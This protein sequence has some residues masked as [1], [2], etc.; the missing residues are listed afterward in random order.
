M[1]CQYRPSAAFQLDVLADVLIREAIL[2]GVRDELPH[3]IA[4]MVEEM[5]PRECRDDLIDVHAVM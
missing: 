4:V 3:S 2:E 5:T 1:W